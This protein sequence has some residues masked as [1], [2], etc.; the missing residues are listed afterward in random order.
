MIPKA[1]SEG[2]IL[3]LRKQMSDK[4]IDG[5]FFVYPIDIYYFSGSRQNAGL[6][7]PAE[8]DPTLFVRKSLQ[9]A[10]EE[11][12]IGDVRAFPSGADFAT[13]FEI[14]S[15]KVGMTFDVM[16]V[17][18]YQYYSNLL[19]AFDLLDISA[20]NRG[21]RS[22]KSEW[23]LK[24][25]KESGRRLCE[26]F[27]LVPS[28]LKP[29]MRERDLAAGIE[30]R[31]RTACSEGQLR[32]RAFNQEITGLAVAGES[33][34]APG[35]FDGPVTGIGLSRSSPFGPSNSV[36]EKGVPILIDYPGIFN[37][38][39]VD[40]TRIFVIGDLD[41]EMKKAFDV[42]LEIQAWLVDNT[43]PGAICEDLYD[44]AVGIAESAG[45]GDKFMGYTG[46][47]SKFVGHGVGLELDELPVLARRFRHP[48]QVGQTIAIEPKF[49][50]PGKGVV[51]I[52]NTFAVTATGCE[53]LTDF[54]DDIV[55]M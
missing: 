49:V 24:Q 27:S 8:G 15:K 14:S 30:F 38:Y 31:L 16:P 10:K 4:G 7:V 20:I 26:M 40:M 2:R 33:A 53:K 36:I 32:M 54:P 28:F 17:Q 41:P 43:R 51:G 25:M 11:S 9:R 50:F 55:Y 47:Q 5:A 12:I 19:P 48:I 3:C 13:F 22:V 23:E 39:I 46:E 52:E 29:G 35:C 45:L 18:Q 37:G 1:E 21:L 42:S 6:W 34:A 44:K